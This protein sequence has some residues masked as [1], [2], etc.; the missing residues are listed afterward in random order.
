[1]QRQRTQNSAGIVLAGG[2]SSRMG[3]PKADLDWHGSTL[4]Y[5]ITGLLARSVV[6]PIVVVAAPDQKLPDLP[7]SVLVV[8]DPVEGLGPLQGLAA[9]LNA[10]ADR[11]PF[12][13]ACST[14]MPFLHPAF[15]QAVLARM[16]DVEVVLP[17]LNGF[18]QPLAAGYRTELGARATELL[19][20]G[21]KT[22]GQLFAES[23]VLE[24]TAEDLLA[25]PA[26]AEFD[27]DL[28]SVR[29]LDTME[30]YE[31]ALAEPPFEILASVYGSGLNQGQYRTGH[32]PTTTIGAAARA[33]GFEM[34]RYVMATVNAERTADPLYPLVRGDSLAYLGG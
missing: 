31:A 2:K 27:P 1:M 21:A 12:A 13:F 20:A 15:V 33:M 30:E 24:L 17:V 3:T 26:V 8:R 5:R 10:V 16:D 23:V 32:V 22:P 29:D 7:E 11:Q 14:D 19:A 25:D 4:L 18:R 28:Q 6:G 9:G 34:T